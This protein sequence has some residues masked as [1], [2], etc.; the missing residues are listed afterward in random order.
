ML[1]DW[2]ARGGRRATRRAFAALWPCSG[3][4]PP[5]HDWHPDV[6]HVRQADGDAWATRRTA[7]IGALEAPDEALFTN[8]LMTASLGPDGYL[9][10]LEYG[11]PRVAIFD[12]QGAFV[13]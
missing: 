3:V 11:N 6:Q 9:Y 7:R 8:R 13:E 1:D 12:R 10:V 4:A 2:P 5:A